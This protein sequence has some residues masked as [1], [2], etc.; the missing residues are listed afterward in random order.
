MNG[1][2]NGYRI[3]VSS[4]SGMKGSSSIHCVNVRHSADTRG[5]KHYESTVMISLTS[6]IS[7]CRDHDETRTQ[8]AMVYG[9]Y[10]NMY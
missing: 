9:N 10:T 5:G 1:W 3:S 8:K 7:C 6:C 4:A 2:V